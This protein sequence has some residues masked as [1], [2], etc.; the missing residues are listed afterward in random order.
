MKNLRNSNRKPTHRGAILREDILPKLGVTQAYFAN[1][2][3]VSRLTVSD[4]LLKKRALRAEKAFR[5]S[6]V[7]GASAESWLRMQEAID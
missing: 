5:I 1:H 6:R 2:L 7:I 3:G 4:L